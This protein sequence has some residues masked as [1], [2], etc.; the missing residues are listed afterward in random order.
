[1]CTPVGQ[2][3]GSAALRWARLPRPVRRGSSH[4]ETQQVAGGGTDKV[5]AQEVVF[6]HAV[7]GLFREG[8]AGRVTPQLRARLK[9]AGIDLDRPLAPAYPRTLWNHALEM[10]ARELWPEL[11]LD[12]AFFLLGR[13]LVVGY[14]QTLMGRALLTM[15]RLLGPRRTLA[16]MTHNFRSG[17][18]YNE[19]RTTEVGPGRHRVWV[20]EPHLPPTYVAGTLDAALEFSG[21]RSLAIEVETRDAQGCT[22]SVRWDAS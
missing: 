9:L 11:P 14:A 10:T 8:L 21:A 7:E 18:N 19:F 20:N 3:A 16:R 12:R 22:Y 4:V 13:Q 2:P 1:M 5:L 15:T 17:G 6:A